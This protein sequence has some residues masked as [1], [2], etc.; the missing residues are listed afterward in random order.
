MKEKLI[1]FE[2]LLHRLETV[3]SPNLI[4]DFDIKPSPNKW[5]KKEIMGHLVDSAIHNIQRFTEI[6]HFEKPY[7]I[8]P[9][10]PDQLV[11]SNQYQ[12]K[13]TNQLYQLWLALNNQILHLS[14][15]Q[16]EDTLAYTLILPNGNEANLY[17]LIE[18]YFAHFYHHASQINPEWM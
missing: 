4:A 1:N 2:L 6:Q 16:T 10:H 3:H 7:R 9:Y 18:D 14:K 5:S 15:N 12:T 13:D 11:M 17:F 8:R